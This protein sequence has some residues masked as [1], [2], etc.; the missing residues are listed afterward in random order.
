M[1]YWMTWPSALQKRQFWH[2]RICWLFFK[3]MEIILKLNSWKRLSHI[4]QKDRC[5]PSLTVSFPHSFILCM[6][7]YLYIFMYTYKYKSGKQKF[8]LVFWARFFH[9]YPILKTNNNK[10]KQPA[11]FL[12][13]HKKQKTPTMWFSESIFFI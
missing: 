10:S 8:Q 3:Y 12:C 5:P 11:C 6:Y 1:L 9:V 2:H 4:S 7:A 13:A